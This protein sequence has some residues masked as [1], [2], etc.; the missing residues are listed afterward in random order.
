VRRVLFLFLDGVGIGV[1]DPRVNPLFAARLPA[2]RSL[3][4]GALPSLG[5]RRSQTALS[6]VL[7]LD[8]TLGVP[9]LPQS[10]TGQTSLFTGVN[11]AALAGKHFGPHPY[12]TLK[13]VIAGQSIF[14]RL[15]D[16]GKTP[17]FANAFPR[18]FFEY[19][20]THRNRMSVTTL[21]CTASGVPLLRTEDLAR[22]R[23]VSADITNAG[24]RDLGHPEIPVIDPREAGARLAGLAR[25]YDFVLYEYW[26]TDKAGHAM[27]FSGA[28]DVLETFDAM[29]GGILESL[30]PA[31]TL[32]LLTSDHG[33]IE[34]MTTKTHTRHPVPLIVYGA[35]A[36]AFAARIRRGADL[37]VV[38]PLVLEYIA[39][40]M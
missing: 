21:S 3:T 15:L 19:V 38:T 2:L 26:K 17:L 40:T 8:A 23:A 22:G 37:T 16:A 32:I 39:G 1:K 11:G 4:G 27:D 13:P 6:R 18:R 28:V 29:L 24:W 36:P 30:D 10:G 34:D 5:R 9:G 14:R 33:N 20:E 35:D 25:R 31:G 12:S 7:P